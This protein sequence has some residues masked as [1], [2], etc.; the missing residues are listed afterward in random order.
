MTGEPSL[1][2]RMAVVF[3]ELYIL[4]AQHLWFISLFVLLN[5]LAYYVLLSYVI[6]K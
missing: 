4:M 5:C 3:Y 6:V 2:S 1:V